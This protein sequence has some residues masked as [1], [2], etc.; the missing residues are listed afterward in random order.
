MLPSYS[1][2]LEYGISLP[3]LQSGISINNRVL[4]QHK[5]QFVIFG[6]PQQGE[7]LS[8]YSSYIA[9]LYHTAP[10][11]TQQEQ[12]EQPYWDYLQQPLQPLMDNL[13]SSTYETFERD[14]PK[15]AMY[16]EAIFQ[17]LNDFKASGRRDIV[18][19]V[20]GAG[21]GPIVD[22][23]IRAER[24]YAYSMMLSCLNISYCWACQQEQS[25]NPFICSR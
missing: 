15:Y 14:T 13:E 20:V 25:P 3:H 7:T 21:R 22:A 24:R 1:V 18:V 23:A 8:L 12:Y 16:E 4:S 9:A 5:V 6:T 2:C 17:A 11:L 10:Q 19:M